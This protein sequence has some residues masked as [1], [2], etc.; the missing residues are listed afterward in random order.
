MHEKDKFQ[1]M[2]C[3]TVDSN[4]HKTNLEFEF[5]KLVFQ[6]P[7]FKSLSFSWA[8]NFLINRFNEADD[9]SSNMSV[10]HIV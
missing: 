4:Y 3:T 7:L 9:D 2:S 1:H 8:M 10:F 5:S 6:R